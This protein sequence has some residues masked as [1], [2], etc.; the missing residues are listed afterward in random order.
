MWLDVEQLKNVNQKL[1]GFCTFP[2][3]EI[4]FETIDEDSVVVNQYSIAFIHHPTVHKQIDEWERLGVVAEVLALDN[5]NNPI[6]VVPKRDIEGKNNAWRVCVYPRMVNLKIKD[7]T[8]R[9][10]KIE[11]I[12]QRLAGSKAFSIIDLK[13]GFN[14]IKVAKEH[15]KKTYTSPSC[16]PHKRLR[17]PMVVIP[18]FRSQ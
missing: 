5:Y 14:Q 17:L 10:P 1:E 9:L 7:S 16:S 3:A 2:G 8:H 18:R 13:S 12:F 11:E 4:R 6:L 15:R